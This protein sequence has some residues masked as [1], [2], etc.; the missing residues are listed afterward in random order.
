MHRKRIL[1]SDVGVFSSCMN[2]SI[3]ST[4]PFSFKSQNMF[5]VST[6][7]GFFNYSY[8]MSVLMITLLVSG[9]YNLYLYLVWL[10]EY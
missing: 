3:P 5:M 6:G 7:Y 9:L 4:K 1:W 8:L 2:S 10:S